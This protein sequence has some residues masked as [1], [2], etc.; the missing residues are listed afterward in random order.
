M[1]NRW[2]KSLTAKWMSCSAMRLALSHQ[3]Q[4]ADAPSEYATAFVCSKSILNVISTSDNQ[5][6]PLMKKGFQ[7][8]TT[9]HYTTP[10]AAFYFIL[11]LFLLLLLRFDSK[12][13]YGTLTFD[14]KAKPQRSWRALNNL[15]LKNEWY[16][17]VL[18]VHSSPPVLL[19]ELR[20]V[21]GRRLARNAL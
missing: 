13:K 16:K 7:L 10:L 1:E 14:S 12:L 19:C 6:S 9:I 3:R 21:Q 8:L 18:S 17:R 20:P 2:L 15:S 11:L 5:V 4:R